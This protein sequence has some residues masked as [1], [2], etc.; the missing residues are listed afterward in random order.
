MGS[1]QSST[2][3]SS[4]QGFF[5]LAFASLIWLALSGSLAGCN[6][7]QAISRTAAAT[8]QSSSGAEAPLPATALPASP[9]PVLALNPADL[10]ESAGLPV[11][12]PTPFPD[13]LRFTFPTQAF[14][15]V[16]IWRPPLYDTPWEPT[17]NDHFY[18]SR[19]IAA[20]EVNWPLAIYRYGGVFFADVVHSGVDIPAPKGTPVLAVGDGEVVWAGWGLFFL[21]EEFSD[22]YGIA[23]AIR[24]DFG[25]LGNDLYTIYGHMNDCYVI[26]GQRV[27]KGDVIGIVG[28][29][30]Q[31]TGPHLHFEVRVG[32][33]DYYKSRNPE[34]WLAPPQGW[35]ILAARILNSDGK[36]MEKQTVNI[37]SLETNQY[38]FVI[39]YGGK[40]VNSD[41]YY[42]ENMA[43]GDLPAGKYVVWIKIE[44]TIYDQVV[45][46]R[47]GM[48][49]FF[50]FIANRG[51]DLD[52]PPPPQP[53]FIPPNP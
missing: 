10:A 11:V 39:T 15:S 29:T 24:H 53:E 31:V 52:W 17:P 13:P 50:R 28:E 8:P 2:R 4:S 27:K 3:Y 51:F 47:P 1:R 35:G 25:Y 9:T 22:P 18:F 49:T 26:R 42:H 7:F 46:I 38:W 34:L 32:E 30:G 20:D 12:L 43:I 14:T 44:D 5:R 6:V 40:S 16:T 45:E 48:V 37:R 41:D 33:N 21:K 36:L 19:P 23:V